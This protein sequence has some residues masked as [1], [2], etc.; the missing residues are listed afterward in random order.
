MRLLASPGAAAPCA[1]STSGRH[2]DAWRRP[3]PG[4][5]P[6]RPRRRA[7]AAAAAAAA[8]PPPPGRE[9]SFEQRLRSLRF[10]LDARAAR[11]ASSPPLAAAAALAAALAARL[12]PLAALRAAWQR[13]ADAA[14][15]DYNQFLAEETRRKWTW[16]KRNVAELALLNAVPPYAFFLAATLVWQAFTPVSL[17]FS[18]AAPLFLAW[19][20]WDRWW[21]S[22]VAVGVLLTAPLKFAPWGITSACWVWPGIV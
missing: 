9:P 13:R 10:A 22:P 8:A 2:T 5:A 17:A 11:L 20:A 16:S 12:A 6:P 14:R 3:P 19:V 7:A 18:L 21:L 1:P 4:R 15:E